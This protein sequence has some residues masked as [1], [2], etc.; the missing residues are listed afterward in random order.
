MW[1]LE[2][3]GFVVLGMQTVSLVYVCYL[4]GLFAVGPGPSESPRT[5]SARPGTSRAAR[6]ADTCRSLGQRPWRYMGSNVSQSSPVTHSGSCSA[7]GKK[8]DDVDAHLI[9]VPQVIRHNVGQETL[10]AVLHE[11]EEEPALY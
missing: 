11:E 6:A 9:K 10:H 5:S 4:A 1:N 8:L 2:R 3:I 7:P